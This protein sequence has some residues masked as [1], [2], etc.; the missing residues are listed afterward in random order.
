M[1]LNFLYLQ[2]H[3]QKSCS[4]SYLWGSYSKPRDRKDGFYGEGETGW[5]LVP[6]IGD[7]HNCSCRSQ[8][9]CL[10]G[11]MPN[12]KNLDVTFCLKEKGRSAWSITAR[13]SVYNWMSCHYMPLSPLL[14]PLDTPPLFQ[15][16]LQSNKVN[17][18]TSSLSYPSHQIEKLEV[19][20]F[21]HRKQERLKCITKYFGFFHQIPSY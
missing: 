12:A 13:K 2:K 9:K 11:Q 7:T 21:S 17:L 15:Q 14:A 6:R 5:S 3:L 19:E 20:T 16:P 18:S 1:A 4:E 10:W 8:V